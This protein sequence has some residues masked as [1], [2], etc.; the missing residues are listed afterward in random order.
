MPEHLPTGSGHHGQFVR[1]AFLRDG[2]HLRTPPDVF[3]LDD[4]G[5]DLGYP[6]RTGDRQ[7]VKRHVGMMMLLLKGD[8]YVDDYEQ[9]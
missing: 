5:V 7:E 4:R 3:L 8:N 1:R 2:L 9:S 6:L